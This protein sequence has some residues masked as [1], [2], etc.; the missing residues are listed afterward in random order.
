MTQPN[1]GTP[2]AGDEGKGEGN[3]GAPPKYEGFKP[4]TYSTQQ[5]LDAAF[6]ERAN[7]AAETAKKEALKFLPEGTNP[8]DVVKGYTEWKA[9]Q[10]KK[11]GPDAL[12]REAHEKDKRELE[13]YKAKEAQALLAQKVSQDPDLKVG[14][15]A[16]P[17]SLLRGTTEEE[18]KA[19]GK[20]L[21][22]F[23]S[24]VSGNGVRSPAYNPLQGQGGTPPP[25]AGDPIRN[26]LATG[27]FQ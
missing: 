11:K 6:A 27:T 18:M 7:R 5:E 17:A 14:D 21:I 25:Q 2:P 20:E 10:D 19:F 15:T 13:Q 23:F 16:I 3:E 12:A 9:E 24:S 8:D 1:E 4:V 22:N 26:Y